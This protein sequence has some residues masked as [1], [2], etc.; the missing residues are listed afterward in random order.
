VFPHGLYFK[1]GLSYGTDTNFPIPV[2]EQ[3]N[4]NFVAC[5][6]RLP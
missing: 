2:D 3:N 6:D 4:P 5:L 1:N